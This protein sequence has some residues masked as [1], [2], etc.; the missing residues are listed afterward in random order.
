MVVHLGTL[1]TSPLLVHLGTF[2][3]ISSALSSTAPNSGA[4]EDR[5][6]ESK[7]GGREGSG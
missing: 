6:E 5:A 4:V 2:R 3:Y 7:L 1:G